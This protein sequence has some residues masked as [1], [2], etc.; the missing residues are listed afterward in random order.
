MAEDKLFKLLDLSNRV[1]ILQG[2]CLSRIH[3]MNF[4][5]E[6]EKKSTFV[7]GVEAVQHSISKCCYQP[8]Y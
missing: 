4:S 6:M 8:Y 5:T 3:L 1:T 2:M 7:F